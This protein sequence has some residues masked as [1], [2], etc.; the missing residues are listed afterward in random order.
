MSDATLALGAGDPAAATAPTRT[1]NRVS[2]AAIAW[3]NLWRSKSRTWLMAGGIGFAGL[4]VMSINSLQIGTFTM[5]IDASARFFAGHV[6]VQHPDYLEDPRPNHVVRNA[7]AK[8]EALEQSGKFDG[9]APRALAFALLAAA[10]ADAGGAESPA[11]GGLVVGVDTGR[12]FAAIREQPAT[13]RYLAGPGEAYVGAVL[14]QNLGASVGDA[15]AVLGNSED[16]GVAAMVVTVVGTFST[17]QAEYDRS[18]MHVHLAE[19]QDAFGL[20]DA[21]HAIALTMPDQ[22]AAERTAAALGDGAT[23]GVAWQRLLPDLHQLAE[24]KYQGSYMIY[25]LLVVLVTF[26]IVN[27]FL[28]TIFERTPEFGM[29]KALGMTPGAIM[30]MLSLEALWMAL[31]GLAATFSVSGALIGVLSVTGISFGDAYAEMT[32]QF[33]VPDRLYPTFG[34]RAALEFS[35][36]VLVLTQLAAAIPALRLRRLRV[37]DALRSEE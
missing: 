8:V 20:Q 12:E 34:Y 17:G 23:V 28:M 33:M 19:F 37:V 30:A 5:T 31:L 36:A 16:G 15:I 14:A 13:G 29:L 18:Q 2:I 22:A 6:Q 24:L 10:D 25:A 9:V 21:V 3:R 7:T 27:A 26:S 11:V 32:Q 4:L 1:R 35:I